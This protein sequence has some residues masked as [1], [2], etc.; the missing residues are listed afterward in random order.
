MRLI[1]PIVCLFMILISIPL[2][3]RMVSA[4][5]KDSQL[6]VQSETQFLDS[7]RDTLIGKFDGV[8]IDTLVAEPCGEIFV[9]D[10]DEADT[11]CVDWRVFT[12]RGSVK[13]LIVKNVAHGIH[14][15][16]EGDLDGDGADDWGFVNYSP[17]ST[18]CTYHTLSSVG[19][20]WATLIPY[21]Q[22]RTEYIKNYDDAED[23]VWL[24]SL[25]M[26]SD[27]VGFLNIRFSDWRSEE[28]ATDGEGF[29]EV[30]SVVQILQKKPTTILE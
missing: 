10:D 21:F 1:Y 18:W 29:Y 4:D 6:A 24:D 5:D 11:R 3:K 14:F 25:V 28:D 8:H 13:D 20:S 12:T 9:A 30:D 22:V 23:R 16:P 15:V 19:G 2:I 26:S 7:Y 27:R 17:I